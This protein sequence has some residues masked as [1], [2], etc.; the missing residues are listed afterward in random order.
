MDILGN[1]FGGLASGFRQL[2]DNRTAAV[3]DVIHS[4][5]K[6]GDAIDRPKLPDRAAFVT[7]AAV[8]LGF[9][10][11]NSAVESRKCYYYG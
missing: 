6:L 9:A 10:I 4:S 1:I 3:F 2:G 11:L 8:G 5:M 7:L